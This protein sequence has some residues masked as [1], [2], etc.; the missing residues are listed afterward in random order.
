APARPEAA[1]LITGRLM[2]ATES[3]NLRDAAGVD[4]STVLAVIPDDQQVITGDPIDGW[5]P[6]QWGDN[7]G[8]VSGTYLADGPIADP[9]ADPP[10]AEASAA[11]PSGN[12]MT[13]LIPQID[14][15][16]LG[17]WVFERN[18][19]WGASDGHTVY[20]DPNMPGDKRFSVMVH[21]YSHLLEARIYGSL[22][23]SKAALS[24]IIGFGPNDVTANESTADCMALMLGATW[25][26]Y[27]CRDELRPAAA[28]IL[29]GALP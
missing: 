9:V 14:P 23:K 25:V 4:G 1:A 26:N 8:W 16:G 11:V 28:A 24:S 6:A 12:W 3:V 7:V 2:H 20:I 18:R 10:P 13:D 22:A 15:D 21:E 17:V 19:A 5:V 29:A 27:G